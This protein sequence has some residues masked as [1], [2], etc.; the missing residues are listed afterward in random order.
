MESQKDILKNSQGKSHDVF[1]DKPTEQF[2]EELLKKPLQKC[3]NTSLE[4]FLWKSLA[5][6]VISWE[7]SHEKFLKVMRAKPGKVLGELFEGILIKIPGRFPEG[8]PR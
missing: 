4:K 8:I 7:E 5:K 6:I 1:L 3:L 2:N